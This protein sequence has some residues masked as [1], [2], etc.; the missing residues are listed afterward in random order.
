MSNIPEKVKND[1]I[2][3]SK[4]VYR[5]KASFTHSHSTFRIGAEFGYSLS[6]KRIEQLEE[7]LRKIAAMKKL[8]TETTYD[9]A[10]N[11]CWHIATEALTNNQSA[12]ATNAIE[13]NKTTDK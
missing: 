6:S 8:E 10:F 4:K 12:K 13:S 3:E 11:R 7:A 9:Y 5:D 2:E 1:I